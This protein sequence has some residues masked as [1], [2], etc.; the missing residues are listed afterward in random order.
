MLSR[1]SYSVVDA[2]HLFET[3]EGPV[4]LFEIPRFRVP[5]SEPGISA[6]QGRRATVGSQGD[7]AVTF[8]IR[9]A[10]FLRLRAVWQLPAPPLQLLSWRRSSPRVP[11]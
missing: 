10:L 7:G 8:V 6:R 11:A 5:N 9:I 2:I 1:C 3:G 4:D